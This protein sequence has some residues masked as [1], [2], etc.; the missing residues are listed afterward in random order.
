MPPPRVSGSVLDPASGR[1]PAAG[2][3]PRSA[4]TAHA[5]HHTGAGGFSSPTCGC[6]AA[7]TAATGGHGLGLTLKEAV[8]H[9]E[10]DHVSDPPLVGAL[11]C[12][13]KH[14]L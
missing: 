10:R 9:V 2:S 3:G 8:T 6:L 1:P 7:R 5:A 4:G 14:Y 12:I 11:G 13:R